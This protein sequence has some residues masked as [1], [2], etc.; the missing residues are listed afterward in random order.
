MNARVMFP[1]LRSLLVLATSMLVFICSHESRA[2][3][4]LENS[5]G[6]AG[7]LGFGLGNYYQG[8]FFTTGGLGALSHWQLQTLQIGLYNQVGLNSGDTVAFDIAL[9]ATSG[10]T[11][12]G[13]IIAS[14][15]LSYLNTTALTTYYTRSF[16]LSGLSGAEL[17]EN[18]NY[19]L[20]L[21]N[22]KINGSSAGD[23]P[24]WFFDGSPSAS[25]TGNP[26]AGYNN[27]QGWTANGYYRASSGSPDAGTLYTGAAVMMEIN[28]VAVAPEPRQLA[29]SGLLLVCAAGYVFLRRRRQ[30]RLTVAA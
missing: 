6:T 20:F 23:N 18:T 30:A 10:G 13:G 11:P 14:T 21:Y 3:L 5:S 9:R 17:A 27:Y 26:V 19:G 1:Q 28:A 8:I 25:N 7:T 29:A 12:S 4:V 2:A 16:S 24:L 22:G 15:T